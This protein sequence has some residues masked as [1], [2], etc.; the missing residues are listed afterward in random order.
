MGKDLSKLDAPLE[1]RSIA[2]VTDEE[3][4]YIDDRRHGRIKSLATPWKKYNNV[5]MGGIEWHTIHTLGGMSGSGK[6]AILNQLETELCDL[7]PNEKFDILSFNFEM[8]ARNLVGR[9]IS[10]A[11]G[12]TMQDLH[13]GKDGLTLSDADYNKVISTRERLRNYPIYYVDTAGTVLEILQTIIAFSKRN[14]DRGILMTLDHTLLV[15]GTANEVERVVLVNLVKELKRAV[16]YFKSVN[17]NF[18]CVILT[19]LN[20]NI[21]ESD[22][23]A[24]PGSQNFPRK[25]DIFGGDALYQM[26]DVV[27]VTMN[28]FQQGMDIYGPNK[29]PTKGMLYWHFLKVREGE[30]VIASM[31]NK[32]AINTVEDYDSQ[33]LNL[34]M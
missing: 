19:Q 7:N 10:K 3:I 21:E 8:L 6:T 1:I 20:R 32:L 29:W 27:L 18:S 26:S 14:P 13:S 12:L 5:A 17:R 4:K 23:L 24:E 33:R 34:N 2:D 22:R 28:P 25:K 30:P 11:V 9:K 15:N 31:T 16:K